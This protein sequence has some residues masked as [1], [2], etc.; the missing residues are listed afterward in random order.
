M[1]SSSL[2]PTMKGSMSTCSGFKAI[3]LVETVMDKPRLVGKTYAVKSKHYGELGEA[4]QGHHVAC[5]EFTISRLRHG[6]YC[7]LEPLWKRRYRPSPHSR[8]AASWQ[9]T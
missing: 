3:D 7:L 1:R 9:A 4:P 5:W 6:N 2:L 8:T